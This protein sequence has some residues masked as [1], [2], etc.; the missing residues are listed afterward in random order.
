MHSLFHKTV[1]AAFALG[2]S[3]SAIG[4]PIPVHVLSLQEP[5]AAPP[6][7]YTWEVCDK[8]QVTV[9][10]PAGWRDVYSEKEN[11][12]IYCV[13]GPKSALGQ[14][15]DFSAGLEVDFFFKPDSG[16]WDDSVKKLE[17]IR[18]NASSSS[19]TVYEDKLFSYRTAYVEWPD[20]KGVV[21]LARNK[22]SGSIVRLTMTATDQRWAEI[23][24][25]GSV[26]LQVAAVNTER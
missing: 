13:T 17:N 8:G 24:P 7:G 22:K 20:K 6:A 10:I 2:V 5:L 15:A 12:A 14:K 26:A 9:L 25:V 3:L 11:G 21:S 1:V 16:S 4:Q 18:K 19:E 23:Q